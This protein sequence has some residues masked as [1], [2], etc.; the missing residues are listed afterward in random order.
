MCETHD[1]YDEKLG[2]ELMEMDAGPGGISRRSVLFGAGAAF[3]LTR[4]GSGLF[5]GNAAAAT[6]SATAEGLPVSRLAM[7][8]HGAWSEG[9][10]SWQQACASAIADGLDVLFFTDHNHRARALDYMTNLSGAWVPSTTGSLAAHTATLSKTGSLRVMAKAAK[11]AAAA[12]LMTI[13]QSSNAF[14]RLRTGI[15][16]Q[17]MNVTFGNVTMGAKT[18]FEIVVSLSSRPATAGR[19]A[20][21]Y[22]LRYRFLAGATTKSYATTS[23]GLVGIVNLPAIHNGSAITIRPENDIVALWPDIHPKDNGFVSLAFVATTAA[24][25]S[26]LIDVTVAA[27][28]FIRTE[29]DAPSVI[30]NQQAIIAAY[31][32]RYPQLATYLSE[33]VSLG[34]A[35]FPHCNVFGAAPK[36]DDMS[37]VTATNFPAYYSSY[38]AAA[39]A[40][41]AENTQGFVTW[42]HPYGYSAAGSTPDPVGTRRALFTSQLKNP[43]APFLGAMG[44]EVGYAAR[45]GMPFQG[46]LDLWDTFTRNGVWITGTGANDEHNR[47]NWAALSN[48]FMTGVFADERSDQAIAAC[49]RAGN[50]FTAH[51]GKWPGATLSMQA[52]GVPMGGVLIG[53]PATRNVVISTENLPA[54]SRLQLLAGSVDFTGVDPSRSVVG[55]WTAAQIGSAG[56]VSKSVSQPAGAF[57]RAQVVLSNGTPIATGNPCIFL[58]GEPARGVPDERRVAA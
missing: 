52:D 4:L 40:L 43:V 48:G 31:T 56:T 32:A 22:F 6:P 26:S 23:G 35:V 25:K 18:M 9:M 21:Q 30:A 38:I 8:V 49:L 19:P 28:S 5:T 11:A 10:Q 42:N 33:E 29:N 34:P 58:T 39:Q 37:T 3:A 45:G 54:G 16:G 47:P 1:D 57:Y 51:A 27:V 46:H 2:R 50:A 36:F 55:E 41:T 12:Q 13:E 7:H 44:L 14:N 24:T 15:G 20:G 53:S 17:S